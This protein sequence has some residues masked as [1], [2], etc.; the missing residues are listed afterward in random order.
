VRRLVLTDRIVTSV[1]GYVS[2]MGEAFDVRD[3]T[4]LLLQAHLPPGGSVDRVLD[5]TAEELDRVAQDGLEPGELDRTVARMS[6]HLLREMDA[7]LNR[8]LQYAVH[9][10]QRAD[11]ALSHDLPRRLAEVTADQ[12]QTAAAALT[13]NR[14]ATVE[15]VPGGAP[16]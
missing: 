15:V 9:E 10:Q 1:G 6:T 4:A 5:V 11:P 14:R 12:V 13:A 7:V 16:R 3:P 2:F 8:A